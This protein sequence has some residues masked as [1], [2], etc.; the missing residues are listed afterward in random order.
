MKK[1]QRELLKRPKLCKVDVQEIEFS[2]Q[3]RESYLTAQK[4]RRVTARKK[5]KLELKEEKR[6]QIREKKKA[7]KQKLADQADLA[8]RALNSA[9]KK[10]SSELVIG[11]SVVTIQEL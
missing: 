8:Q 11:D 1:Y 9:I 4:K 5:K 7:Q 3:E 6:E 10:E 2:P